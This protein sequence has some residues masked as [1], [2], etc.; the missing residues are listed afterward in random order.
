M[1]AER[2]GTTPLLQLLGRTAPAQR[3]GEA[4]GTAKEYPYVRSMALARKQFAAAKV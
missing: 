4:C 3:R 1:P 2:R